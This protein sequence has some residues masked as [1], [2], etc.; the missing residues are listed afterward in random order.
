MGRQQSK[1]IAAVLLF[2]LF[3]LLIGLLVARN[4]GQNQYA[5]LGE[6]LG[7]RAM[8]NAAVRE[9]KYVADSRRALYWPNEERYVEAIPQASR[10][11]IRDDETLAEFK[12]Y[13][14]GP[15]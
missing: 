14:P 15:R 5:Q 12:G 4:M 6:A 2:L 3:G 10:V 8:Q 11:W 9:F 7:E 13:K 1:V